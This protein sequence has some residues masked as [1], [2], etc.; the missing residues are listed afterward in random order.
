MS[1][2]VKDL[3]LG[4]LCLQPGT[5]YDI[6]KL[7]EAAFS[8]FH[9][10]S[11]GSIYPALK[12]LQEGEMVTCRVEPGE[13]HPDRKLFEITA[14]GRDAF[15]QTLIDTPPSEHVRSEF[16]VLMFFAH[17]LPTEALA[18]KLDE[19]EKF[20]VE[21][22]AYL[23]G[24]DWDC[25]YPAGMRYTIAQGRAVFMAK[26]ELLREKREELLATHRQLPEEWEQEAA[27]CTE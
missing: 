8:H 5:G 7:F 22:L 19:V 27:A 1:M 15:L 2:N 23:E 13:K 18:A 14:E 26:L 4:A 9:S 24:I 12:Q 6:K 21:K 11:Y 25:H 20:Y 17:L 10:A 3:C 16:M